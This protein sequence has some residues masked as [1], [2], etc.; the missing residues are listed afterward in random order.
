MRKWEKFIIINFFKLKTKHLIHMNNKNKRFAE[1]HYYLRSRLDYLSY[2][3]R[4]IQN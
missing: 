2:R 1:I 4:K 3:R